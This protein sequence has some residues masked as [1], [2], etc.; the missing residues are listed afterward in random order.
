MAVHESRQ[1]V[2]LGFTQDGPAN[3]STVLTLRL[4]LV[5]SNITGLEQELYAVS[6]PGSDRYGQFLSQEQVGSISNQSLFSR[7]LISILNRLRN[8]WRPLLNL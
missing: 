1:S 8:T 3:D 7:K 6:T 5:Q 4:A 2:P